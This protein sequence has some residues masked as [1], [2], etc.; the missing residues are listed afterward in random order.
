MLPSTEHWKVIAVPVNA[1]GICIA[2]GIV[3]CSVN[4]V[5]VVPLDAI[6]T[7]SVSLR[8]LAKI[9]TFRFFLR[10]HDKF[11]LRNTFVLIER[12]HDRAIR[13]VKKKPC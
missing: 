3:P 12:S 7:L 4:A 1:A 11:S 10:L 5:E 8:F 2:S 9:K 13:P 6:V